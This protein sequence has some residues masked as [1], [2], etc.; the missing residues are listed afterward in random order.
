MKKRL[1]AAAAA[2]LFAAVAFVGTG[3]STTLAGSE[4]GS[5][6]N[7]RGND[8][9]VRFD[10]NARGNDWEFGSSASSRGNDWE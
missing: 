9:E 7:A 8:W 1:I 10:S 2:S 4:P 6:S 3:P 5:A